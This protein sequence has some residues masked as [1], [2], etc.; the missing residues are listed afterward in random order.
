[1]EKWVIAV[2]I[3]SFI[4][5]ILAL[6]IDVTD[7]NDKNNYQ[8]VAE[9]MKETEKLYQLTDELVE[10]VHTELNN[11]GLTEVGISFSR[12]EK[13]LTVTVKDKEFMQNHGHEIK[14]IIYERSREKN[15]HDVKLKF[16]RYSEYGQSSIEMQQLEEL[17]GEVSK[18][19]LD[20]LDG[21]GYKE[22]ILVSIDPAPANPE[23]E[24]LFQET[25]ELDGN[26]KDNLEKRIA[27]AIY[28]K[29]SRKFAVNI[30][31]KSEQEARDESW[32]PVF[33]AI[34]YEMPKQFEEYNGF[35]YSFH[36]EPLQIIIKTSLPKASLWSNSSKKAEAIEDYVG[37]IIEIKRDELSL[38]K[39]PYEIIV[40]GKDKEI[41]NKK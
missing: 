30:K 35:G 34:T 2:L 41:L 40:R 18:V 26:V 22:N 10:E 4:V 37:Q 14:E 12:E 16:E 11:R 32:H 15:I 36:P 28:V 33:R 24:V 8:K 31:R 19:T 13:Q 7:F 27:E 21:A 6:A 39:I 29:T 25:G 3:G 38:E 23:I 9:S 17:L 20:I 5:F 1:M